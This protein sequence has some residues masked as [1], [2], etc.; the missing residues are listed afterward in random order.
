MVRNSPEFWRGTTWLRKLTELIWILPK[1]NSISKQ[2]ESQGHRLAFVFCEYSSRGAKGDKEKEEKEEDEGGVRRSKEE[3][4]MWRRR[5]LKGVEDAL[6]WGFALLAWV[7]LAEISPSTVD[8]EALWIG[9]DV[10]AFE[11]NRNFMDHFS[12]S[13]L[14]ANVNCSFIQNPNSWLKY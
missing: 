12:L 9:A 10:A 8:H 14:G 6:F 2:P 5:K 3:K 1:S 4:G 13:H 11:V 7:T